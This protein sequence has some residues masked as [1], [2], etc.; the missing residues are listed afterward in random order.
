VAP[1]DREGALKRAEK[2]LRQ[3][4]VDAAIE[5]YQG[6]LV[7]QPRDWNSAN[8][9]GDLFVRSGQLDKG[10]E[11]YT[12]I[13]DHLAEEGFYPKASALYKKILKVKPTEEYALIRSGDVASKLG[14]LADAKSAYQTVA[15][16]RRKLGNVRGAAEMAVRLGTVD[17][18]DFDARYAAARAARELGDTETALREL[19][20][21]ALGFEEKARLEEARAA[22]R[23]ILE[24]EPD[25]EDARARVLA[26]NI[27]SGEFTSAFALA[28]SSDEL[29]QVAAALESAGRH[30]EVLAVWGR[31]ADLDPD[32]VEA[33]VRVVRGYLANNDAASARRHLTP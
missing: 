33:R 24:L 23:D 30:A 11:Q 26:A 9:L 21:A 15:D 12:R 2:A 7:A 29:R 8:A 25:D 6:I 32:D 10:V 31:I 16:R 18:E 27:A 13:A 4:R 3:G 14:L 20:A 1:F 28:T 5:E 22:Y 19:R 17:P